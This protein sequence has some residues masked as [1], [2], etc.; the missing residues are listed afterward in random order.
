MNSPKL[1][2]NIVSIIVLM[3]HEALHADTAQNVLVSETDTKLG[4]LNTM[5]LPA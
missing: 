3:L 2:E 1:A 5:L 4:L